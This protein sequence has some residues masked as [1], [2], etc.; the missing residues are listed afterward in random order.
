MRKKLTVLDVMAK[1]Y[2]E[3]KE[4]KGR[5]MATTMNPAVITLTSHEDLDA[6]NDMIE[7]ILDDEIYRIELEGLKRPEMQR[8]EEVVDILRR[9]KGNL[10]EMTTET[11][12]VVGEMV[13]GDDQDD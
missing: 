12:K 8:R 9:I 10:T 4:G 13:I 3:E 5:P 11:C 1:T 2:P 6:L 7:G